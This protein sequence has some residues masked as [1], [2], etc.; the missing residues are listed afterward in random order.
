MQASIKKLPYWAQRAY[1]A[2]CTEQAMIKWPTFEQFARYGVRQ[3]T[4]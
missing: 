4:P 3:E 2:G 1:W